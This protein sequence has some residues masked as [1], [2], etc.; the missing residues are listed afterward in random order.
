MIKRRYKLHRLFLLILIVVSVIIIFKVISGNFSCSFLKPRKLTS[1]II[2]ELSKIYQTNISISS[3]NN[4]VTGRLVRNKGNAEFEIESPT[5]LSGTKIIY[6][7]D[8]VEI[9][10]KDINLKV[11]DNYMINQLPISVVLMIENMV[12]NGKY[13]NCEI[14]DDILCV[15]GKYNDNNFIFK[16]DLRQNKVISICLED[17]N[18]VANYQV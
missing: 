2:S 7:N 1:D 3:D 16:A 12:Y 13:D 15:E 5:L 9:K 18:I 4:V 10:Y 11:D 8:S 6:N 14:E 17:V